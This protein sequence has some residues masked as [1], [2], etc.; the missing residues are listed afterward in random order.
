MNSEQSR[1][2]MISQMNHDSRGKAVEEPGAVRN[3]PEEWKQ[4]HQE[5][6]NKTANPEETKEMIQ[7]AV[8]RLTPKYFSQGSS[9][10]GSDSRSR[11]INQMNQASRG[12][13]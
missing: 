1:Q 3:I 10:R 6:P 2:R 5:E 7:D 11:M 4:S 13:Q 8:D 12:D 9:G